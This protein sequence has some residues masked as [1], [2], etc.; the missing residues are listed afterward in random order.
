MLNKIKILFIGLVSCFTSLYAQGEPPIVTLELVKFQIY[1][2]HLYFSLKLYN[3][4]N[5]SFT[6]YKPFI[7]D[8]CYGVL[9]C[10]LINKQTYK[11]HEIFPCN[12]IDDLG[13]IRLNEKNSIYLEKGE[14]F[15]KNFKINLKDISP[16]LKEGIYIFYFEF[17]LADIYFDTN[18][19]NL[20]KMN[21]VS[22]KVEL[23]Y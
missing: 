17:N 20:L 19:T 14:G 5:Q 7:E 13:A 12:E 18:L 21:L 23:E 3:L 4:D 10:S 2:N 1:D 16:Y 11:K 8:V 6:V 22:N 15:I 9:K